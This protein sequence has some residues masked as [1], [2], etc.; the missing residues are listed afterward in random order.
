MAPAGPAQDEPEGLDEPTGI[1]ERNI[2]KMA[3][4]QAP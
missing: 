4:A 3:L 2:L 1:A